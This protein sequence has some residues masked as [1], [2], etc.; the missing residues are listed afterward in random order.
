MISLRSWSRRSWV[1]STV[2]SCQLLPI[3]YCSRSKVSRG[4]E[5]GERPPPLG[6]SMLGLPSFCN[7]PAPDHTRVI[8][9][10]EQRPL[11][12]IPGTRD[13]LPEEIARWHLVERT[14]QE[15][16]ERY[17]FEEVRTPIM[18]PTELFARGIGADTDIVGK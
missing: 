5:D 17:G 9:E 3:R 15:I 12:T 6:E 16:F 4:P 10:M 2:A 13:I 7:A 8:L 1:F 14:A 18:E 11:A